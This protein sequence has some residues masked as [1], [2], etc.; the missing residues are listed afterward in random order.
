[1]HTESAKPKL[2]YLIVTA[3][4][5]LMMLASAVAY[6]TAPMME[7]A[8]IQLGFP[9]YF[10]IELAIGK[11][12]GMIALWA[13]VPA[14]VRE[15]VYA[16]FGITFI[17]AIIAHTSTTGSQTAIGPLVALLLLIASYRMA[18]QRTLA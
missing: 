2:A 15:W 8:F 10:R 12:L 17:S 18:P 11:I 1:M 7:K 5:S 4:L 9:A 13:S 16:G 14:N 3:L 6:L